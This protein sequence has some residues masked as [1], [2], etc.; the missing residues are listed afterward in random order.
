MPAANMIGAPRRKENRVAA[1]WLR[2]PNSP[3][4]IVIPDRDVPGNRAMA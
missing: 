4:A 1:V 2:L 3:A